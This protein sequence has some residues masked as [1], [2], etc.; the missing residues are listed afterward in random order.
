MMDWVGFTVFCR[1]RWSVAEPLPYPGR[2]ASHQ[3]TF[4]STSAEVLENPC[5][6]A[7]FSQ[8]PKKVH[9]PMYY[10]GDHFN[11]KGSVLVAGDMDTYT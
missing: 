2:D 9:T 4:Y 6:Y 7:K 1:F 10:L 3:N 11:V 8:M 5:G